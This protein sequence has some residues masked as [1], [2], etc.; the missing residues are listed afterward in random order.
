VETSDRRLNKYDILSRIGSII[1]TLSEDQR[2]ILLKRLLE[3]KTGKHL[4]KKII[5]LPFEQQLV[6]LN[7]LEKAVSKIGITDKR[8]HPR[9][10]CL[11][12]VDV[13]LP[14]PIY[15]SYILDI[16]PHGAY[17]ESNE[18]HSV[19]QE[20]VLMFSSPDTGEPIKVTGEIIWIDK[21]GAG[22]KFNNL[23]NEQLELIKS[24][25]ELDEKVYE[26]TS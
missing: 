8:R 3:K 10:A 6:F 19:G 23:N 16:N 1:Q 13:S 15:N 2:F 7:K 24:F 21:Q 14:A 18:S 25:S 17:I 20:V 12:N 4:L 5:D 26:I 11:I 22:V 9:K